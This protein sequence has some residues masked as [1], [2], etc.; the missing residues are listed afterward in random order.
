M[1]IPVV[2][3]I[4]QRQNQPKV[5]DIPG[6]VRRQILGSR[7]SRRVPAGAS[8]AV[9][10]GSRGIANIGLLV[11]STLE[12]L[13]D[14]GY[15]PFIV[16]AMGSHGGATPEGQHELL[17]EYGVTE[18]AL[19]VP[20]KTDMEAVEL[21][22]N[23]WGEP[24]YWDKNAL[25]AD[26]VVT[27]SRVKPHTDFRGRY[28]SGI[29]KMLVIGLGKRAGAAQHHQYGIRGLRDMIPES[30][31]VVLAKTRFA[32]GLAILENAH[33]E[34]AVIQAV[35]PEALLDTEPRL[36]DEARGL[37]ARIP[38]DQLDL[39]IVGELG[40]NYSGT[41]MDVNVLG[42]QMVEG[43]PDQLVPKITRICVLDLSPESHGN[44][45]GIGLADLTTT[46]LVRKIDPAVSN[47]N[48]LTS[49]FMLRSKIPIDL[50]DDRA[51]IE[52]GLKT[53][54]QPRLEQVRMAVIPNTLEL[55]RLWVTGPLAEEAR[56]REGL[57]VTGESRELPFDGAGNVCQEEVFPQS[58][59]GKRWRPAKVEL[60]D[61]VEVSSQLRRDMS[62]IAENPYDWSAGHV[63]EYYFHFSAALRIFGK[64]EDLDEITR[65]LGLTPTHTH[66]QGDKRTARSKPYDHDMWSYEAPV[67]KERDLE[68]HVEALWRA[69][70]PHVA[71]L[72]GLKGSLTVDVFCGY[73]SN[74]GHAGFDVSHKALVLFTE[75]E[76]PFGVSVVI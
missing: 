12:T 2:Y 43:E 70:R 56:A 35:E 50:P 3:L 65:T 52:M 68:E 73:R 44:A 4:E 64:I 45:V 60:V 31:K 5:G 6:E 24:V 28:E 51:C 75:L 33:E 57:K 7:L 54:W 72:K 46:R 27:I 9:A 58:V 42:R 21:G 66:R 48:T 36:L 18:K 23:S 38:F 32:L 22:T 25:T 13:R 69:V 40:K 19:Q 15:R 17:A 26:A 34:T 61:R 16:A 11:R 63:P 53:C 39:L 29:V 59:R 30:A 55:S 67:L 74:C 49:C 37:M 62:S 41:G 8:V 1:D 14:L 76:V 47:L 20:V 71:Y 10:V